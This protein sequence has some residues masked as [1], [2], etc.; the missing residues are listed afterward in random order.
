VRGRASPT[1]IV[2]GVATHLELAVAIADQRDDKGA[3]TSPASSYASQLL[4][5]DHAVSYQDAAG[6]WVVLDFANRHHREIDERART[7]TVKPLQA[8]VSSRDAEVRNCGEHIYEV[9]KAGGLPD[10]D[11]APILA[12]HHLGVSLSG[13]RRSLG[14]RSVFS[15]LTGGPDLEI[16]ER[17]THT[18]MIA[19]ARCLM[20]IS[21]DGHARP[22]ALAAFT[23]FLRHA[24]GGHPALL[25][26][27]RG[28]KQLPASVTLG[29]LLPMHAG[30]EVTVRV[31]AP[32]AALRAPASD[33]FEERLSLDGSEPIDAVLRDTRAPTSP[34]SIEAR[35][36]EALAVLHSATPLPGLLAFLELTLEQPVAMPPEVVAVM[37]SSTDEAVAT[38]LELVQPCAKADAPARLHAFERL[39]GR[40]GRMAYL[41]GAFEAPVHC[42]LNQRAE[43]SAALTRVLE[44]NP[45]VTGA[46]K[47]LG[48]LFCPAY[49]FTHAW[50]CWDR[51]RA[52]APTHSLLAD[53][54]AYERRL[55]ADHPE[56]FRTA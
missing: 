27:I 4:W 44:A 26:W 32:T 41:L 12:E 5:T 53:I 22:D 18:D 39:R 33:G 50:L 47:D 38:L 21:H 10:N 19:K 36:A 30:G 37:K 34:S 56:Y 1:A 7:V 3:I 23:Q 35:C 49:D 9:L 43:A 15:R 25:R 51:A 16:V 13:S 24:F 52:L 2:R 45:R 20:A 31:V 40:A 48:D 29:H 8:L 55:E 28:A 42:V 54:A 46:W 14:K 6:R 17:K 11:F